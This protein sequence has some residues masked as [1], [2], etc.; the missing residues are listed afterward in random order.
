MILQCLDRE[1]GNESKQPRSQGLMPAYYSLETFC[2][3]RWKWANLIGSFIVLYSPI[4]EKNDRRR[5]RSGKKKLL[6]T[7]GSFIYIVSV[8][9]A[10]LKTVTSVPIKLIS[11]RFSG[12]W[13]DCNLGCT[14][15]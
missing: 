4:K 3:F 7:F 8:W 15:A 9:L 1:T 10:V 11:G 14:S 5:R 6:L 2:M 12:Y 13:S